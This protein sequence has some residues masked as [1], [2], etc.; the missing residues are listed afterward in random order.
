MRDAALA[1]EVR[2]FL[3]QHPA[4]YQEPAPALYQGTTSSR[5]PMSLRL[6][7]GE[8]N[9]VCRFSTVPQR[10]ENDMGF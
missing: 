9:L 5:V 3:N 10:A 8:E 2:L 6:A 7:Q 1:A 4:F